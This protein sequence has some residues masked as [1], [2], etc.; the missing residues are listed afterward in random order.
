MNTNTTLPTSSLRQDSD[1][2]TRFLAFDWVDGRGDRASVTI[3][4]DLETHDGGQAGL[5]DNMDAMLAHVY[6]MGVD[7]SEDALVALRHVRDGLNINVTNQY[8]MIQERNGRIDQLE[9]ALASALRVCD[10]K[11]VELTICREE[12]IQRTNER[13]ALADSLDRTHLTPTERE[14]LLT[15]QLRATEAAREMLVLRERH[16]TYTARFTVT[17]EPERTERELNNISAVYDVS[18]D[19]YVE[20]NVSATIQCMPDELDNEV[21]E[22]RESLG[23]CSGVTDVEYDGAEEDND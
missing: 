5:K 15:E 12:V 3:G 8:N 13:D 7:V 22:L 23:N 16:K 19:R 11:D 21:E 17:A 10:D 9:A 1:D 14:Q 18:V 6:L 20:Y 4:L 2:R